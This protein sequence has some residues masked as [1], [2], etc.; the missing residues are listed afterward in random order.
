M[1]TERQLLILEA[2][3]RDYTNEGQPIGS[4]RLEQQLPIH[5]SSA[6]IRNEMAA[7]ERLGL[8]AKEHSSSGRIPSERGYRYYVD[9]IMKPAKIDKGAVQSIRQSF[10]S[11]FQKVDE[12]VATSARI[13]S[14]LTQYTAISLKPESTDI[15]LEGFRLVPIGDRQVM[16]IL[17]TSDG[18]V[19]SQ[20]YNLPEGI[21]GDE[22]E[23]VIRII[24]DRVVG[25]SLNQVTARLHECLPLI[26]QYLHKPDGFMDAFGSILDKA[27]RKQIYVGGKT[28]LLSFTHGATPEQIKALYSLIDR[29]ADLGTL[30]ENGDRNVSVRLGS[31]LP[32]NLLAHYSLVSAAYDDGNNGRGIIAILGPTN[33]PYSKVIGLLS[34][35]SDELTRRIF[36]Y[37]RHLS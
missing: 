11:E 12:I 21:R 28:N 34:A 24:N 37:Y 4:K 15:R 9:H 10:G 13:L 3:I 22:L 5:A 20:M 31:E 8:I 35:F 16:V 33:M 25:L 29:S 32:D 14:D 7:L 1:L 18:T 17:V 26:T 23:S 36:D 2:I 30:L 27:V 19:E 6:T